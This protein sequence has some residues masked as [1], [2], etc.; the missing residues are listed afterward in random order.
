MANWESL[1]FQEKL[2][3]AEV[4]DEQLKIDLLKQIERI[5][6]TKEFKDENNKNTIN[7]ILDNIVKDWIIDWADKR[8]YE[9]LKTVI[10]TLPNTVDSYVNN[11]LYTNFNS[12][13]KYIVKMFAWESAY[14][15]ISENISDS[16]LNE[17]FSWKIS[18]NPVEVYNK[19]LD[20]MKSKLVYN[21]LSYSYKEQNPENNNIITKLFSS[22][23]SKEYINKFN[24]MGATELKP[25]IKIYK[26]YFEGALKNCKDDSKESIAIK[27]ILND[28]SRGSIDAKMLINFKQNFPKI[29][30]SIWNEITNN[31]DN[32]SAEKILKEEHWWV[33]RTFAT[34]AKHIFEAARKKNPELAENWK[35][36]NISNQSMEHAYVWLVCPDWKGWFNMERHDIS[37]YIAWEQDSEVNK[38]KSYKEIYSKNKQSEETKTA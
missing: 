27:E 26:P 28:F 19:I 29:A 38:Q 13:K 22:E 37:W 4:K 17:I 32:N 25:H 33:C 2:N 14:P 11:E 8:A 21:Y 16:L 1:G 23:Y 3:K 10:N 34:I 9:S 24:K 7:I 12:L 30:Q 6:T 18:S 15:N 31:Y 5:W 35:L 36:V 20:H